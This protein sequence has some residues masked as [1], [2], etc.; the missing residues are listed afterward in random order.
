MS[1]RL[2]HIG[3]LIKDLREESGFSQSLFA[4][5]LHTAQSAIAR[6]EEVHRV[7][8]VL[9]SIGV[10]VRWIQNSVEIVPPNRL[11][12]EKLNLESA[13][14]IRS[15]ILLLAPLLHWSRRFTLPHP[16]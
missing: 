10:S 3:L 16:G 8:E 14:R 15:I 7:I 12:L 2:K 11:S 9:Q 13:G 1:V 5:K 4:K 6:I